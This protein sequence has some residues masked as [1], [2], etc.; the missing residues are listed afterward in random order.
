MIAWIEHIPIKEFI[1]IYK[2]AYSGIGA[3]A[4]TRN[5]DIKRYL[6]WL[7]KRCGGAFVFLE[8]NKIVGFVFPDYDWSEGEEKIG[9]IH[10]MCVAKEYQGKGFG[11]K[12]LQ[13]TLESFKNKNLK[14]AGLW[15]GEKNEKAINLYKKFGFKEAFRYGVWIRMTKP[16]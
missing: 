8:N 11:K 9:E 1:E 14:K 2:S 3:Y 10:E 13:T 16:L 5:R 12:L 6:K 15:V 4:Y 7:Y